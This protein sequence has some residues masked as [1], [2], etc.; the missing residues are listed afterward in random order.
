MVARD[1][2]RDRGPSWPRAKSIY[3]G[4]V[5]RMNESGFKALAKWKGEELEKINISM[6]QH[7]N[8]AE[9]LVP[10]SLHR[11]ASGLEETEN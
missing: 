1:R 3:S 9:L 5:R 6:D 8:K 11:N 10:T 4:S 2:I 7:I